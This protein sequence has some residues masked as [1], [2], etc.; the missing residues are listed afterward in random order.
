MQLLILKLL[1]E[2]VGYDFNIDGLPVQKVILNF[3]ICLY[4]K[5][6]KVI[7]LNKK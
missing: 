7:I 6:T 1:Y 2:Y 5:I 3:G 4:D